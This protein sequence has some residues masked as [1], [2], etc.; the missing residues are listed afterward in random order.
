MSTCRDE[1]P[2]SSGQ[3]RKLSDASEVTATPQ[4]D[5]E[6][7]PTASE[8]EDEPALVARSPTS[9]RLSVHN[10]GA[11]EDDENAGVEDHSV[12]CE[13]LFDTDDV[14]VAIIDDAIYS[15]VAHSLETFYNARLVGYVADSA[16]RA[17]FEVMAPVFAT[18]EFGTLRRDPLEDVVFPSATRAVERE[19]SRS[20]IDSF[21]RSEIPVRHWQRLSEVYY[22][23]PTSSKHS[24]PSHTP[25]SMGK[26][27]R[28]D[29]PVASRPS[30]LCSFNQHKKKAHAVGHAGTGHSSTTADLT[31][32]AIAPGVVFSTAPPEDSQRSSPRKAMTLLRN[33]HRLST[34]SSKME[35]SAPPGDAADSA[36]AGARD[37]DVR[38][39]DDRDSNG[40]KG[41]GSSGRRRR[42][43][44]D[45]MNPQVSGGL[46][47]DDDG[48]SASAA[49]EVEYS[50]KR[51]SPGRRNSTTILPELATPFTT[52]P[53][54]DPLG[55]AD[56]NECVGEKQYVVDPMS[57][58]F[59]AMPLSPGV[60]LQAGETTKLG[61]ELPL[62]TTRMRKSTFYV[63]QRWFAISWRHETNDCRVVL[64]FSK[65]TR[66]RFQLHHRPSRSVWPSSFR[67]RHDGC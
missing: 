41:D 16:A 54:T 35:P 66:C 13:S 38:S 34:P 67:T 17:L 31:A 3:A 24:S 64:N 42:F 33:A 30:S 48:E 4:M 49:V 15:S 18:R 9:R 27:E 43:S 45:I 44:I 28:H 46:L 2:A 61:P 37:N 40:A 25:R 51:Q 23:S 22:G 6:R 47:L 32:A 55:G 12:P 60:K 8:A 58:D 14:V 29:S 56:S 1:K 26:G 7:S 39:I 63:S 59:Q 53:S 50:I 62:F 20:D 36:S 11:P 19:S 52:A 21:S 65:S 57:Q 5:S 10:A